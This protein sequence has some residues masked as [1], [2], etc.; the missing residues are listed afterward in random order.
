MGRDGLRRGRPAAA[1]GDF[2]RDGGDGDSDDDLDLDDNPEAALYT[3]DTDAMALRLR[4]RRRTRENSE[5]PDEKA[6]P[7]YVSIHRIR[8]LVIAA[9]G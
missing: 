1:L 2:N 9:I 8:R 3:P 5:E 4:D 7:V 6:L